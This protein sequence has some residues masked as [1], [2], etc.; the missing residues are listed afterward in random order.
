MDPAVWMLIECSNV[1]VREIDTKKNYK[2]AL[3]YV[4]LGAAF[5]SVQ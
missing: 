3:K 5:N 2:G 4:M 1:C